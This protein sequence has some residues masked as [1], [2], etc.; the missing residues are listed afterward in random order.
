MSEKFKRFEDGWKV[1]PWN[2]GGGG[3][4]I[5]VDESSKDRIPAAHPDAHDSRQCFPHWQ[6]VPT[7][8]AIIPVGW[9]LRVGWRTSSQPFKLS[10]N[11]AFDSN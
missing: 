11:V 6:I 4:F 10:Q 9:H 7:S 5:L 2:G 1:L 3:V 8:W